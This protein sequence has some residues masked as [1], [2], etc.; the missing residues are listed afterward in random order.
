MYI[1]GIQE[2]FLRVNLPKVKEMEMEYGNQQLLVVIHM[3]ANTKK[4]KN[5]DMVLING[6]MVQFMKAVFKM[7]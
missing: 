3:K 1:D 7:I 6:Q 2:L 5:M 4:I